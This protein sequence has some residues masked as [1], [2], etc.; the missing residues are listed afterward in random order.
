MVYSLLSSSRFLPPPQ[1][2]GCVGL[3]GSMAHCR[4]ISQLAS[5][6]RN[7]SCVSAFDL[8]VGMRWIAVILL[9]ISLA[10][11]TSD[12]ERAVALSFG[13]N[14]ESFRSYF[15]VGFCFFSVAAIKSRQ[16]KWCGIF[17]LGSSIRPTRCRIIF[18]RKV[19]SVKF[20]FPS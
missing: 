13:P 10:I 20:F 16:W 15:L 4:Y 19:N 17:R 11:S 18:F 7:T 1:A 3:C 14:R 5:F 12:I 9:S 8:H 6:C 2:V